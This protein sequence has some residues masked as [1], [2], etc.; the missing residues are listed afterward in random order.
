MYL[1][2]AGLCLSEQPSAQTQLAVDGGSAFTHRQEL[3]YDTR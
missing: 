2:L 3:C 1:A